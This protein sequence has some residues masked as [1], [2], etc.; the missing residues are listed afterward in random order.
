VSTSKRPEP[1]LDL[2]RTR[3]KLARLGLEHVA[4]RLEDKLSAAASDE[5]QPG[6]ERGRIEALATCGWIREAQTLLRSGA[7]VRG[8]FRPARAA[9]A[10]ARPEPRAPGERPPRRTNAARL[11][12]QLALAH[13]IERALEEGRLGAR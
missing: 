5:I 7:V 10:P 6:I 1:K 12:R 13:W 9:V 8:K 2:D 11:A 4:D 3:E